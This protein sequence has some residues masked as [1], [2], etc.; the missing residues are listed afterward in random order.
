MN[1]GYLIIEIMKYETFFMTILD[2][3]IK[4][5]TFCLKFGA[6]LAVLVSP[7]RNLVSTNGHRQTDQNGS[8]QQRRPAQ[9]HQLFVRDASRFFRFPAIG[10][11]HS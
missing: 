2:D 9:V 6:S 7:L 5:V 3:W 11:T 4:F 8:A 1:N 10:V